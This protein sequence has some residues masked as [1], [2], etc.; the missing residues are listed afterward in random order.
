METNQ[1]FPDLGFIGRLRSSA[2]AFQ[3]EIG[4]LKSLL[5]EFG[6]D[7]VTAV[8]GYCSGVTIEHD[9]AG[10][11]AW[12]RFWLKTRGAWTYLVLEVRQPHVFVLY[13][14]EPAGAHK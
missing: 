8:P 7:A 1:V 3:Q 10:K 2:A 12:V 4:I 14:R 5:E 9:Q 13:D 11:E 6:V